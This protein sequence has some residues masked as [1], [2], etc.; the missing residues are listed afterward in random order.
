MLHFANFEEKISHFYYLILKPSQNNE[1]II[2]LGTTE[3]KIHLD[4]VELMY[5]VDIIV[6]DK[7]ARVV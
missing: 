2:F 3:L 4:N 5:F 7:S 6:G 1:K